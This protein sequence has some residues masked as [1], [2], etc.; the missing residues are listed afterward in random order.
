MQTIIL[1]GGAGYIGS[2]LCLN[3]L[4]NGYKVIVLLTGMTNSLR[5]QTQQ[6][7]NET[8]VGTRNTI[9]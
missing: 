8:F 5:T 2:H 1:T 9:S 3:L 4:E 6:R 7:I